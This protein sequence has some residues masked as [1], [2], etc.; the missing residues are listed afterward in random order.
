MYSA[1]NS[2]CWWFGWV[3]QKD[4]INLVTPTGVNRGPLWMFLT[5]DL[6]VKLA[7]D[8]ANPAW[9]ALCVPSSPSPPPV[10]AAGRSSAAPPGPVS[11][12]ASAGSSASLHGRSLMGACCVHSGSPGCGPLAHKSSP[13]WAHTEVHS[14][15]CVHMCVCMLCVC[16]CLSPPHI[17][18][19][20]ACWV[21][22]QGSGGFHLRGL[23][24]SSAPAPEA[25]WCHRILHYQDWMI[26]S[27]HWDDI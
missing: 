7:T 11:P 21:H 6:E 13:R 5:N 12:A 23:W 25:Y 4:E 26:T 9:I 20:P 2:Q 10:C 16:V 24:H 8:Q 19:L 15:V 1:F 17:A 14:T 3:S 22:P 27:K 18:L